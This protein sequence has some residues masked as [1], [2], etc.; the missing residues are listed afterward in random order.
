MKRRT[1]ARPNISEARKSLTTRPIKPSTAS[2]SFMEPPAG[3]LD[4]P[5]EFRSPPLSGWPAVWVMRDYLEPMLRCVADEEFAHSE[6]PGVLP[7]AWFLVEDLV[8]VFDTLFCIC[9]D[10]VA[11]VAEG[12]TVLSSHNNLLLLKGEKRKLASFEGTG[13]DALAS[14]HHA[15]S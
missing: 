7:G 10:K 2:E 13:I 12:L 4:Q 14:T 11:F 1:R 15:V 3:G 9:N 5:L 8:A 6:R